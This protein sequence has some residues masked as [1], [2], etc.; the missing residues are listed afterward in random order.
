MSKLMKMRAKQSKAIIKTDIGHKIDK[1]LEKNLNDMR[2][3]VA[4]QYYDL[5]KCAKLFINFI[6]E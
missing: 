2:V 3:I 4:K 1:D 5:L 6:M